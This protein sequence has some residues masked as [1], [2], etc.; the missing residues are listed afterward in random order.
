MVH[1]RSYESHEDAQTIRLFFSNNLFAQKDLNEVESQL[2]YDTPLNGP[3]G[4]QVRSDVDRTKMDDLLRELRAA[5][6]SGDVSTASR[7][8][9]ELNAMTGSVKSGSSF[10][11]PQFTGQTLNEPVQGSALDYGFT[12]V[13]NDGY[14]SVA[15][16]TFARAVSCVTRR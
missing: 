10:N 1:E 8:A 3:Q 16:S 4:G 5:R 13:G 12:T 9:E 15:T 14:W 11:G 2:V 6:K 7:L